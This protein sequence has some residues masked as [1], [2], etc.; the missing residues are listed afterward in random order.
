MYVQ[1]RERGKEKGN[2]LLFPTLHLSLSPFLLPSIPF[3]LPP[4]PSLSLSLLIV[5]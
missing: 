2:K 5:H 1:L 3:S 4:P